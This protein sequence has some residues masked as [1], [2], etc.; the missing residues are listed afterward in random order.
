MPWR[1]ALLGREDRPEHHRSRRDLPGLAQRVRPCGYAGAQLQ[2]TYG[3]SQAIAS[4]TDGR[5]VTVAVIDAFASPTAASDLTTY[6]AAHGLPAPKLREVVPPGIYNHP[7]TKK[8]DPSGWAG[9]EQLDLEAVHTMA[10]GANIL[11]VGAPNNYQPLDAALNN[12]VDNHAADIIT[13]SY[14]YGRRE[15]A[16]RVHHSPRSTSRSR[17]RSPASASSSPRATTVTRPAASRARRPRPTCPASSP[18]VTAVGGTSLGVSQDN[19]RLFELGWETGAAAPCRPVRRLVAPRPTCTAAAAA[20]R[21]S[22]PSRP[23]R[24]ASSRRRI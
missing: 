2:G 16:F 20:P 14:G 24:P 15:P 18:W 3:V 11:F 1:A 17:R 8:W 12:V 4:R 22:S 9:E 19:T 7:T 13:N 5:G 23:T 6:S 21:G 10:P